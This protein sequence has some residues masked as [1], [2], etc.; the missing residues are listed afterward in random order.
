MASKDYLRSFLKEAFGESDF[1]S[2]GIFNVSLTNDEGLDQF[3]EI[4]VWSEALRISGAIPVEAS[5]EAV[6]SAAA[7]ITPL[8]I[9]ADGENYFT[10]HLVFT[11]NI[12]DDGVLEAIGLTATAASDITLALIEAL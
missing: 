12:S 3:V 7:K 5:L 8:G 2:N 1:E 9:A 10:R 11:R 6:V 4:C